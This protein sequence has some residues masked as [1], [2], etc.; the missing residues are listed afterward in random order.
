[1]SLVHL[2][3]SA[4][5]GPGMKDGGILKKLIEQA[6]SGETI[7]LTNATKVAFDFLHVADAA[8]S[9]HH[10]S[11][12]AD[13]PQSVLNLASGEEI[14]LLT[15]AEVICDLV[16]CPKNTIQNTTEDDDFSSR[17]KVDTSLLE[18]L[19]EGTAISTRPFAEK[20]KSLVYH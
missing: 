10:L 3:I 14:S 11:K 9:I 16:G 13:W 12:A 2:R 18:S 7:R 6:R 19:L 20:V 15:L 5:Y 17:A 4:L 8:A 1:M